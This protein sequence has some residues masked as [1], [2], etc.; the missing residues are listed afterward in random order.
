MDKGGSNNPLRGQLVS[1]FTDRLEAFQE[2]NAGAAAKIGEERRQENLP[3]TIASVDQALANIESHRDPETGDIPGMS[4]VDRA[5]DGVPVL[6]SANRLIEGDAGASVRSSLSSL[7]ERL[8]RLE[9]GAAVSGHEMPELRNVLAMD[10]TSSPEAIMQAVRAWR[11]RLNEQDI[12]II[13]SLGVQGGGTYAN[14]RT[15]AQQVAPTLQPRRVD[16]STVRRLP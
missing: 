11:E 2:R 7:R 12:E 3:Q 10:W 9:S 1:A 16:P 4:R 15:G 13:Q 8:K 5:L 14:R 6:D